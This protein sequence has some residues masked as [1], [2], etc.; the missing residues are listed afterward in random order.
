MTHIIQIS[1]SEHSG[2]GDGFENIPGILVKPRE[3]DRGVPLSGNLTTSGGSFVIRLADPSQGTREKNIALLKAN[4][5]WDIPIHFSD[6]HR[7]ILAVQVDREVFDKAF[8]EWDDGSLSCGVSILQQSQMV[9][10]T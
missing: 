1:L 4:D 3:K 9:A 5:W 8:A 2:A 6:K 7:G 10:P